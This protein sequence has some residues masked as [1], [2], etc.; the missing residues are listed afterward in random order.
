VLRIQGRGG[1][2]WRG[3]A[4]GCCFGVLLRGVA[5]G[6]PGVLL[7]GVVWGGGGGGYAVLIRSVSG[8]EGPVR[9]ASGWSGAH[10][11]RGVLSGTYQDGQ[12]IRIGGSC[13]DLTG[14][15]GRSGG[16]QD[17]GTPTKC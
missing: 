13:Q 7:R 4:L 9:N 15:S 17:L 10:Q 3:V 1:T 16:L 14:R 5:W 11:D 2:A 12:D 8:W 6:Y